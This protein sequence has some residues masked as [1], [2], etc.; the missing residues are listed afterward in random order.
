MATPILYLGNKRYSSW[1]LRPWLALT[2]GGIAFEER[3]LPLGQG[4]HGTQQNKE[5]LAISPSGRVPCLHADD[6]VIYDSLAIC[7]WAAERAPGLWPADPHARALA[8]AAAAE[9]HSG[10]ADLRRAM[11]FNLQRAMVR[12]PDWDEAT[13]RDLAR[14]LSLWTELRTRFGG[15]EPYLMGPRTI[16][17]AFYAPVAARFRTYAVTLPTAAQAYCETILSDSAFK[18]W[19]RGA[20]DETWTLP[21]TDGI[22]P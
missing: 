3:L 6:L 8:R 1:S 15:Q 2:W 7:E 10:F 22:Y 4:G 17:D 14:L 21:T 20:Q 18:Q 9:M 12:A 16:V 11:P 13:R 19:E 5:I